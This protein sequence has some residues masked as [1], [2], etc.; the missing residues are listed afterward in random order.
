MQYFRS[1][2]FNSTYHFDFPLTSHME[3]PWNAIFAIRLDFSYVSL[4][5]KL[6]FLRSARVCRSEHAR[7]SSNFNNPTAKFAERG[8]YHFSKRTAAIFL[9]FPSFSRVREPEQEKSAGI[10]FHSAT[11]PWLLSISVFTLAPYWT[12][13]NPPFLIKE[14]YVPRRSFRKVL[15]AE[16]FSARS[17]FSPPQ[18]SA[19]R[20]ENVVRKNEESEEKERERAKEKKKVQPDSR[21][22]LFYRDVPPRFARE[23]GSGTI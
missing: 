4:F 8:R 11:L 9:S 19:S 2:D 1:S 10:R 23:G 12:T 20:S 21:V 15:A 6:P 5:D 17:S 16:T 22:F 3:K 13:D 7:V 18:L 14:R